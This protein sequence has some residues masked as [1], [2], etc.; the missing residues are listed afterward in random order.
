MQVESTDPVKPFRSKGSLMLYVDR[1]FSASF[2][3]GLG[4]SF[5]SLVEGVPEGRGGGA[6]EG[7]RSSG[8]EMCRRNSESNGGRSSEHVGRWSDAKEFG[9]CRKQEQRLWVALKSH[10]QNLE[11]QH[12]KRLQ[13]HLTGYLDLGLVF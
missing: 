7:S 8:R 11:G 5:S 9:R 13:V 12:L 6:A 2:G 1:N 4:S 10:K 3:S